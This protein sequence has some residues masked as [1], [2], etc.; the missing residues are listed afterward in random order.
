[1]QEALAP[2]P[3]LREAN[4]LAKLLQLARD[5]R[6]EK[7]YVGH[8]AFLLF[9][10]IHKCRPFMWEGYEVIDLIDVHAPWA[11]ERCTRSCV[12]DGVC[13]GFEP[14]DSGFPVM[15]PVSDTHP[16]SECSHYVSG[17]R[18][19]DGMGGPSDGVDLDTYYKK[20]E[21]FF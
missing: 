18:V 3:Q 2:L 16:L 5:I 12:V 1:M 10:L 14:R 9:A 21:S 15:V 11:E 4:I 20:L 19:D 13:C 17:L 8:S 6:R 7:T